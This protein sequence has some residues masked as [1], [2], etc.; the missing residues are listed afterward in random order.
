LFIEPKGTH[1]LKTDQWKEDFLKEIEGN[2]QL[3]I[4][5]EN[6]SYKL[7]GMPFFNEGTKT[8]FITAFNEKLNLN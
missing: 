3:Q 4:L 1:L 7:I 6:E 5:A 2:Y 8:N